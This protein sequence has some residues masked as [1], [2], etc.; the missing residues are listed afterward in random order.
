[1]PSKDGSE[2]RVSGAKLLVQPPNGLS[3]NQMD[4]ILQCH[5]AAV[6][7]GRVSGTA[8]PNDPYWLPSS[9]VNI[10][11]NP[12]GGNFAVTLTADSLRDNLRVF[13]RASLY[14]DEHQLA[15]EPSL[16]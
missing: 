8:V 4:R 6:L 7:L 3:A 9:W 11:V 16:Q 12:E 10:E 2:N 13:G 5:S 1:V 14:A 15:I